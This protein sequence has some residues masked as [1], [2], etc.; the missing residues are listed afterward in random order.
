[1]FRWHAPRVEDLADGAVTDPE[2]ITTDVEHVCARP[3]LLPA[4]TNHEGGHICTCGAG[5]ELS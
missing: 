5:M 2:I 1:M 4:P 3:A